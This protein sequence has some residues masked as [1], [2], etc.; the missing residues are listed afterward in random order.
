MRASAS[1]LANQQLAATGSS[2][3]SPDSR[4]SPGGSSGKKRLTPFQDRQVNEQ[5]NNSSPQ[6]MKLYS[7]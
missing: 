7:I 4:Q 3:Q 5:Y 1:L 6:I 2:Q